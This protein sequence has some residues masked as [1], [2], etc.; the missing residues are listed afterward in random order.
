M[1]QQSRQRTQAELA[2]QVEKDHIWLQCFRTC[3]RCEDL[4]NNLTLYEFRDGSQVL[5]DTSASFPVPVSVFGN[6]EEELNYSCPYPSSLSNL[7][8]HRP[9]WPN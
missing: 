7:A 5:L 9:G 1:S 4:P 3:I 8:P 2:L 6:S